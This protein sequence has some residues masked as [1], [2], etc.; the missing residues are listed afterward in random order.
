MNGKKTVGV[1]L[2]WKEYYLFKLLTIFYHW[3]HVIF[4]WY[5]MPVVKPY[6]QVYLRLINEYNVYT[7]KEKDVPDYWS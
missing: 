3:L 5:R 4:Y 2:I 6:V 7:V 1:K